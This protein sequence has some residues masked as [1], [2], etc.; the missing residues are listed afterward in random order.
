[1]I[2][3]EVFR[4]TSTNIAE[5]AVAHRLREVEVVFYGAAI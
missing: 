4:Q 5:Q 1:M 2:S 3:S